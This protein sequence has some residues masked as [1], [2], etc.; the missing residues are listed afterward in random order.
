MSNANDLHS[1]IAVYQFNDAI[2]EVGTPTE[3][4]TFLKWSWANVK[5]LNASLQNSNPE[6]D[7]PTT[8]VQFII[9]KDT[10]INYKTQIRYNEFSYRITS[11]VDDGKGFY[12]L[13]CTTYNEY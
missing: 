1:R 11:I 9:R 5:T 13:L 8:N 7:I 3:P 2:N 10:R 12:T 4:Y 6:G